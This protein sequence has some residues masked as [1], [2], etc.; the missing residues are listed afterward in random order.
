MSR[1]RSI[2]PEFWTNLQVGEC[3]RDARLLFI[4]MWNFCDDF[5]RH[6]NA[7]KQL[8]ALVFPYDDIPAESV[9]RM[10]D[11]L[12][13][14]GL[15]KCYSVDNKEFFEVVG[16]QHQKIDRPQSPKYPAPSED[17]SSNVRRTLATDRIG[18]DR[19]GEDIVSTPVSTSTPNFIIEELP[20][21]LPLSIKSKSQPEGSPQ[22]KK[23][24]TQLRADAQP[25]TDAQTF[26]AAN[27]CAVSDEWPKFRDYHIARASVMADWEAAWRTWVRNSR[28]YAQGPPGVR[29]TNPFIDY[30]EK[31]KA[32]HER[33]HQTIDVAAN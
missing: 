10:I 8:K 20:N 22:R 12:S 5:G 31:L 1:I 14:N 33:A 30:L 26:A 21:C 3:S 9:R 16:W 2:K 28:R 11:E 17:D 32:P 4:G 24:R 7:P 6:P 25:S 18:E 27:Q 29:K 19:I 15:I 23:A 13:S